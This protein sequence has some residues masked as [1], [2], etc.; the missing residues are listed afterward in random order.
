MV[1]Q[2]HNKPCRKI[3]TNLHLVTVQMPGKSKQKKL[4][5]NEAN[6]SQELKTTVCVRSAHM[7]LQ[8][9][10]SQYTN[11]QKGRPKCRQSNLLV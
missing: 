5:A 10:Y 9:K 7:L 8:A 2:R 6:I 11:E 1:E 4:K 3:F